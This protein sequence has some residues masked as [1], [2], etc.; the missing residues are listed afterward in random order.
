[1]C[2]GDIN[3][4]GDGYYREWA[5]EQEQQEEWERYAREQEAHHE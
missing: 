2:Y 4:G 3:Y 1:M 5:E